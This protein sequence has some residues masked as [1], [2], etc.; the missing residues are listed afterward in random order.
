M[1]IKPGV[2]QSFDSGTYEAAVQIKGSLSVWLGEVAVA[3]NIP[4]GEMVAGRN[5]AVIFFDET[6]PADAVLVAV[7]G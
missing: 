1:D 2:I 6:N 4:S 5:C 3:R 7:Y